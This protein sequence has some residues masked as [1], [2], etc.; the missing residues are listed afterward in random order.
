MLSP[1]KRFRT[2]ESPAR[3]RR[4]ASEWIRRVGMANPTRRAARQRRE[5]AGLEVGGDDDGARAAAGARTRAAADRDR[6]RRPAPWPAPVTPNLRAPRRADTMTSAGSVQTPAPATGYG[7]ATSPAS[8]GACDVSRGSRRPSQPGSARQTATARCTRRRRRRRRRMPD[9]RRGR[10]RDGCPSAPPAPSATRQPTRQSSPRPPHR[11][12]ATRRCDR[13]QRRS[14]RA[15]RVSVSRA[16]LLAVCEGTEHGHA[17]VVRDR[18]P[19]RH[20]APSPRK[21]FVAGNSRAGLLARG[22]SFPVPSHP[23]GLRAVAVTGSSPLT[24]AGQR[25]LFTL[26]PRLACGRERV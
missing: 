19:A 26:F 20:P 17:P 22:S 7:A 8:A 16:C 2:N 5:D 21:V 9:R 12:R 3:A 6:G 10:R 1:R 13:D 24:A 23:P 15:R 25:G 4:T 11:R 18:R 14:G